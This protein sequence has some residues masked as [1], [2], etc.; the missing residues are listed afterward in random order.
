M[1]IARL[2]KQPPRYTFFLNPYT[3]ARF[4]NCPKCGGKTRQKKLP[5][6]IHVEG[7]AM[8]SLNQTCRYCPDC[9][10]L[11]SHRDEI[12]TQLTHHLRVRTSAGIGNDYLV[13][14]T[15]DRTDWQKGKSGTITTQE[16]IQALHDFEDV[17]QFRPLD[18]WRRKE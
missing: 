10:L 1:K 5:L 3:D 2:G 4:T 8:I 16:T 14:G 11:I 15:L 9:D 6:V 13:I 17:V 12:E 18:G 7:F